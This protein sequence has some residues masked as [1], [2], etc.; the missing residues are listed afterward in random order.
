[1]R[2]RK[3][4][5]INPLIGNMKFE[6]EDHANDMQNHMNTMPNLGGM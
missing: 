6:S 5:L 1:M 2:N 4:S 3:D